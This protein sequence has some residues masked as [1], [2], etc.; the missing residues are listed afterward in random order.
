MPSHF[1]QRLLLTHL[2][3]TVFMTGVIW[4]VQVVH[5]PL[6]A[7]V[8]VSEFPAYERQHTVSTTWVVGPPMLVEAAT[9]FLLFW[10]R[11]AGVSTWL[12]A[13]GLAL[14]AVI[15]MSTALLQV[16][17][18]EFLAERFD[19]TVQQRLVATNW[20]RTVA[21]SLRSLLA[22]QMASYRSDTIGIVFKG[23]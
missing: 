23:Q 20:V 9:A 14:L 17:C 7:S 13:L 15:W 12:L 11:P 2:A 6:F 10:Y 8:S 19:A 4:F 21:W 16:P 18:H 22:L 3:A 1:S 5:Y